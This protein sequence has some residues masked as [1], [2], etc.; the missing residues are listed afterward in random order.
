MRL[1]F[2]FFVLGRSLP[3][4]LAMTTE[5]GL[6]A[7]STDPGEFKPLLEEM[8]AAKDRLSSAERKV[9]MVLKEA[10]RS[11]VD[12]E[13]LETK[14]EDVADQAAKESREL[15]NELGELK[16]LRHQTSELRKRVH[17][18]RV[19]LDRNVQQLNHERNVL[20]SRR[21]QLNQESARIRSME[22]E[23]RRLHSSVDSWDVY[24]MSQEDTNLRRALHKHRST[25]ASVSKQARY[26]QL[27]TGKLQAEVQQWRRDTKDLGEAN[28]QL[29]KKEAPI[30]KRQSHVAFLEQELRRLET[31]VS[32]SIQLHHEVAKKVNQARAD[33]AEASHQAVEGHSDTLN[34]VH[35]EFQARDRLASKRQADI[36]AL[37][38]DLKHEKGVL[39]G[40][41]SELGTADAS[42]ASLRG[43]IQDTQKKLKSCQDKRLPEH[44]QE[45]MQNFNDSLDSDDAPPSEDEL[46]VSKIGELSESVTDANSGESDEDLPSHEALDN[47]GTSPNLDDTLAKIGKLAGLLKPSF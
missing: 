31:Q 39:D 44:L 18:E 24:R 28:M 25:E 41:K 12:L 45:E 22:A 46:L 40:V 27:A 19:Y 20:R 4:A 16:A 36:N 8:A 43:A 11:E 34:R 17:A 37:A 7:C 21:N 14:R 26:V 15:A 13:K 10:A 1:A 2:I 38:G 33:W 47:V 6:A 5:Q 42:I 23:N 32:K 3:S 30:L 35:A 29:T 9:Q